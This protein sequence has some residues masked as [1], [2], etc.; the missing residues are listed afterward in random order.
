VE[1]KDDEP[2]E[3][4]KQ[5]EERKEEVKSIQI[6]MEPIADVQSVSEDDDCDEYN[7]GSSQRNNVSYRSNR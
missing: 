4:E 2:E 5:L 3:E 7:N 1:P 6:E